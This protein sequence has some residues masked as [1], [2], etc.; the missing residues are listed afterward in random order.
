MLLLN[1]KY[2]SITGSDL[3]RDGMFLEVSESPY[4]ALEVILEIFYSDSTN[5]FSITLFE[6]NVALEVIEEAIKIAKYRLVPVE[7]KEKSK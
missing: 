7:Q 4:N 5:D 2:E 1:G 6:E 3:E